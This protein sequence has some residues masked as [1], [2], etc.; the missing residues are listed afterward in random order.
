M[1]SVEEG[2]EAVKKKDKKTKEKSK[3]GKKDVVSGNGT[4]ETEQRGK[5]A[6]TEGAKIAEKEYGGRG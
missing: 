5:A 1:R 2:T 4:Y 3:A 6:V